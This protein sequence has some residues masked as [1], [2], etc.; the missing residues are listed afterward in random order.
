MGAGDKHIVKYLTHY[1]TLYPTSPILLI[2]SEPAHVV[3][4]ARGLAI[5]RPAVPII[6]SL[7]PPRSPSSSTS[8]DAPPRLL[9]HLFS[10]AGSG[11]KNHLYTLFSTTARP[12]TDDATTLPPHVTIFDSTPGEVTYPGSIAAFSSTV[13]AG[14]KRTLALPLVHLLMITF[15][16]WHVLLSR[17]GRHYLIDWAER[18]NDRTGLVSGERRRTYVYSEEDVPIP[19]RG[20]ERH[21]AAA[22]DRGFETRLEKF[23]GSQHVAHMVKDP[24]RYWRVVRETWEGK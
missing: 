17:G 21:A 1:R 8:S 19:W 20:I 2:K 3:I 16:L 15:Y 10:N 12:G 22:R 6:R 13:P 23:A 24:E 7:V 9:I 18:H 11:I 14:W 5:T 4:P